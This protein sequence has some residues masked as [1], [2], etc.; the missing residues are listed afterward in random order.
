M[1]ENAKDGLD[2]TAPPK[3]ESY[4][5]LSSVEQ[6]HELI[7][8]LHAGLVVHAADTSILLC[9]ATSGQLLGLSIDQMM[10]KT[11]PD[12]AW[13]F[14]DRDNEPMPLADYPVNRVITTG[15]PLRNVVVGIVRPATDDI[16]WALCN[17]FPIRDASGALQQIVVTFIDITEQRKAEEEKRRLEEHLRQARRMESVG[18]LAGGVAHD[19]NNLLTAIVGNCDLIDM[20]ALTGDDLTAALQEIRSAADKAA[21]LTRQLLA[22]SR[23][24][25][26]QP[27]R[28]DVNRTIAEMDKILSRLIGE[29]IDFV[30]VLS[31]SVG[32]VMADP[33][34]IEQVVMNLAVN[35]RDAMPEG[36]KLML[37]T[38]EVELDESYAAEHAEVVPGRY[39]MVSITDNGT[40]MTSEEQSR[41]F[42]P[43]FTTKEVGKGTGLG[44][45]TVHGVVKQ[46]G[47]HIW[48]YSELGQGTTF[49]IYLPVDDAG[50]QDPPVAAA[51]PSPV[52]GLEGSETILVVE[53]EPAV[54][55]LACRIL[56]RY[57]YDV[58]GAADPAEAIRV[59]AGI[60]GPVHLLLTDVV[61]PGA[62]GVQL[63][64]ELALHRPALKRLYMSGYTDNA[65]VHHG[66]LERGTALLEK[67]FTAL[68]LAQRVRQVLDSD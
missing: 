47:G 1:T 16:V 3:G 35:A 10:G 65:I 63:A 46:S 56:R 17:A 26:L 48:L 9:N 64:E 37:E 32:S 7:E 25:V 45:S 59:C 21:D 27:R 38:A 13:C 53:D 19:F 6:Y 43:F 39:A 8:N 60:P 62:S 52:T 54:R 61:M 49:K 44:L 20:G 31:P 58:H 67:P 41:A 12:P 33:G 34:Q 5:A 2:K 22:F 11:A 68:A 51:S 57:G 50:P 29:D 30:T 15:A 36:G 40:G 55:T 24:Q 23:K 66:V 42:E 4:G 14:L 18:Q 28:L